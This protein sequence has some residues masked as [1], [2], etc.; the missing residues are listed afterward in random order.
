MAIPP[1]TT[2]AWTRRVVVVALA[3]AAGLTSTVPSHAT[4]RNI[5]GLV[6]KNAFL[7]SRET[8]KYN[9]EHNPVGYLPIGTRVFTKAKPKEIRNLSDPN[10][11]KPYEKEKYYF[12][13]SNIGIS[14]L[15]RTD[16]FIQV[17]DKP[18][19]VVTSRKK[20][21]LYHPK[22]KK[23]PLL[24][25]SRELGGNNAYAYMELL[26]KEPELDESGERYYPVMIKR[27]GDAKGPKEEP[28]SLSDVDADKHVTIM[29]PKKDL[30]FPEWSAPREVGKRRTC[31]GDNI[32]TSKKISRG[33]EFSASLPYGVL[34][35]AGGHNTETIITTKEPNQQVET[36]QIRLNN[37]RS[38][39]QT[40]YQVRK[41]I[42]CGGPTTK[43]LKTLILSK[44]ASPK[45]AKEVFHIERDDLFDEIKNNELKIW[46][47]S[48]KLPRVRSRM[49]VIRN[50]QHYTWVLS[51]LEKLT[52]ANRFKNKQLL[53][54]LVLR[55]ISH[56]E[57]LK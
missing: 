23:K 48:G 47:S 34:K 12:V 14:G 5:R 17:R 51:A 40:D 31:P 38:Y 35:A 42:E 49:L 28:A 57:R 41:L 29:D 1:A 11:N 25:I 44:G 10:P 36:Y 19:A 45:E 20:I 56:F 54:N 37:S 50:E 18:V 6:I 46:K 24:P 52:K 15:L 27:G 26:A 13:R 43:R 9:N 7:L 33:G 53:L 8:E 55:E 16:L 30:S 32:T 21:T 39:E 22:N 4:S 2:F 3:V